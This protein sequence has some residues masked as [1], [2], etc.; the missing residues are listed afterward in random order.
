[1]I[2]D[3]HMH[4]K[5]GD[6]YQRE[7]PPEFLVGQLD[8]AGVDKGVIFAMSLPCYDS[9]ELT[10]RGHE[11]FPDRFIPFAHVNCD[12]QAL[13]IRELDRVREELGWKGLKLHFG[14][15]QDVSVEAARSVVGHAVELGFVIL[16]DVAGRIDVITAL[17]DM[18]SK[19]TFIVAHLGSP[20]DERLA[21]R[22][23]DLASRKANVYLDL[24]YSHCYWKFADAVRVAGPEKLIWGSDAPLMH[25][26]VE[27][28]KV[29]VLH[30]PEEQEQLILGGNLMRLLGMSEEG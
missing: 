2:I 16:V 15:M 14:E 24:S 26:Y 23:I 4:L 6:R 19:G 9:N 7:V 8:Q 11:A 12:E 18:F 28:A 5:G 30:L 21:E 25:P 27:M 13:A 22:F 20:N 10:R 17:A 29:K 1:M 3:C